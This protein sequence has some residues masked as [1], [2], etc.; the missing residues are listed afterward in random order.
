MTTA[1]E[2]YSEFESLRSRFGE[3]GG[4]GKEKERVGAAAGQQHRQGK[5][6]R[7]GSGRRDPRASAPPLVPL[8]EEEAQVQVSLC[9]RS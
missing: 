7:P 5:K 8:V 3:N 4:A 9:L 1:A 2:K 6:R